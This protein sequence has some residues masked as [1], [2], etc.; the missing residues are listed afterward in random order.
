MVCVPPLTGDTNILHI[1]V[2]VVKGARPDLSAVPRSRPPACAGFLAL[3]QRCWADSPSD[4]PNFQ[5][6]P[7]FSLSAHPK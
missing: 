6:T 3:M 5:G 1:M 2:K 7:A 4:R